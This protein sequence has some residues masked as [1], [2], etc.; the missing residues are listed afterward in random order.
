MEIVD[1]LKDP[2]KYTNLGGKIT[3]KRKGSIKVKG[4]EK[5]IDEYL[6]YDEKG[7][8]IATFSSR[9]LAGCFF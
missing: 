6:I 9:F 5:E 8:K 3:W 7:K 1:F 4:I 2:K